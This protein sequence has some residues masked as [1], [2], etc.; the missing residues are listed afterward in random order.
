MVDKNDPLGIVKNGNAPIRGIRINP[1]GRIY[2]VT[3]DGSQWEI[4]IH[5]MADFSTIDPKAPKGEEIIGE[6][7]IRTY[8]G[9]LA[10][11]TAMAKQ[12]GETA[13]QLVKKIMA[14]L[15]DA[16]RRGGGIEVVGD[17][18]PNLKGN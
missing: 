14:A 13:E 17:L 12:A 9:G 3:P 8:N 7:V 5:M 4:R 6:V 11:L 18:P 16:E 15:A 2:P 10:P 1:A